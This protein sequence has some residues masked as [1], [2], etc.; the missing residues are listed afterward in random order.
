ML[1]AIIQNGVVVNIIMAPNGFVPDNGQL[2]VAVQSNTNVSVGYTYANGVFYPPGNSATP[3]KSDMLAYA[4]SKQA[5]LAAA[6]ITVNVEPHGQTLN[7]SGS[8]NAALQEDIQLATISP[9]Q[10]FTWMQ[11]SGAVTLTATQIIALYAGIGAYRQATLATLAAVND[12]INS[13][14]I[15]T[16]AEIND[17][18]TVG[19]TAWPAH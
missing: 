9:S 7:V 8:F 5:L 13:G 15:T 1:T 16:F 3:S 18:T 17:P 4:L 11:D 6:T 10:S 14:K 19:L 2:A 12:A